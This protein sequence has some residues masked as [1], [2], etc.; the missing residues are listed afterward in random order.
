MALLAEIMANEE[1]TYQARRSGGGEGHFLV[2]VVVL[3]KEVCSTPKQTQ[4]QV[5]LHLLLFP[6][7]WKVSWQCHSAHDMS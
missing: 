7:M 2:I 1:K 5:L 3:E 6:R 4:W